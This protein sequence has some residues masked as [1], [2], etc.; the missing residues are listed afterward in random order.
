MNDLYFH[1]DSAGGIGGGEELPS[2]KK[3]DI[4]FPFF[5]NFFL[6]LA[7]FGQGEYYPYVYYKMNIDMVGTGTSLS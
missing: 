7:G 5:V 4:L 1:L 2:G 3:H 6:G